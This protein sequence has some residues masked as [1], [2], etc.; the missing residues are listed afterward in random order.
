MTEEK[1][2]L[3][4]DEEL[5]RELK[6]RLAGI[7]DEDEYKQ[8]ISEYPEQISQQFLYNMISDALKESKGLYKHVQKMMKEFNLEFIITNAFFNALKELS[9]L[10]GKDLEGELP[11]DISVHN[12]I[13]GNGVSKEIHKVGKAVIVPII[14][15]VAHTVVFTNNAANTFSSAIMEKIKSTAVDPMDIA[16]IEFSDEGKGGGGTTLH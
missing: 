10:I 6:S 5:Y 3:K 11:E 13:S 4:T 7:R 16:K 9:P 14:V 12:I 2:Q 8:I 15:A 1:K